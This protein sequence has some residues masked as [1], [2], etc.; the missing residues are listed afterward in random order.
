MA[1]TPN[2]PSEPPLLLV[3]TD[4]RCAPVELREQVAYEQEAAEELLVHLLA[5]PEVAEAYLLSTCNRTEV[6]LSPRET[7]AAYA[8]AVE[9]VFAE[10]SSEMTRPGRLYVKRDGDAARHLLAVASGLESMVVGEPEILG[11]VRQAGALAEAVGASGT[12]I[13]R[14]VRTAAHAGKR[15]RTET[16]IATGAVSLGYTVVE[17]AKNIFDDFESSRVLLV[18]AGE[19]GR[20]VARNLREK[21]LESLVVAN[22]TRARA[23]SLAATFGGARVVDFDRRVAA[24]AEADIVVVTTGAPEPVLL[25]EDFRRAMR[26]RPG[27]TLLV[28]DLGVPRNVEPTTARIGNLFLH[29]IDSLQK[30]IDQNLKRRR[31]ERHKVEEVLNQELEHFRTWYRGL[32]AEP[33][34]ARLQKQAERIR[35]Q[36]LEGARNRFPDEVH[37]DLDLL[38]RALVRKILHHPSSTLR[39]G[40]EGEGALPRLDLVREL[41]RLDDEDEG[42]HE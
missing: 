19:T 6:Y 10:R 41:F 2:R 39:G 25:R 27:R 24:A 38:T 3:G 1:D 31:S 15:A 34:I 36:E 4:H 12:V 20:M 5:R 21:G 13:R 37:A 17:L 18:G 7:E 32:E 9:K 11:Q 26:Q 8:T 22:R 40:G 33:L 28:V 14:L 30:L 23:E 29:S 35:R 42:A 16:A